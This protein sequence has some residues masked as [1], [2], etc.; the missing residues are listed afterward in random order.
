MRSFRLLSLVVFKLFMFK[1]CLSFNVQNKRPENGSTDHFPKRYILKYFRYEDIKQIL[2]YK[3][4]MQI[5]D[6]QAESLGWFERQWPSWENKQRKIW[7][8]FKQAAKGRKRWWH[9]N[10]QGIH[11]SSWQLSLL[12]LSKSQ[13]SQRVYSSGFWKIKGAKCL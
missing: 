7:S 2:H 5:G 12:F 13:T 8:W 6:G 10:L 11:H 1:H 3:N 4:F 9:V